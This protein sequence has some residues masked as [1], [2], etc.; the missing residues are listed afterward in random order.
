MAWALFC[1]AYNLGRLGLVQSILG[2]L[3]FIQPILGFI[4]S[5]PSLVQSTLGFIHTTYTGKTM[6]LEQSLMGRCVLYTSILGLVQSILGFIPVYWAS[7]PVHLN[8]ENKDYM[9]AIL[10]SH[11]L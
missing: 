9:K 8:W 4:K 1:A 10:G 2:Q 11:W 7:G 6:A 3:G 5:L